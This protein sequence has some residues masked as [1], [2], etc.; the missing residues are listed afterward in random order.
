M[1]TRAGFA[2]MV[3][4]ACAGSVYATPGDTLVISLGPGGVLGNLPSIAPSI[5]GDA[6][7]V[8]FQSSA[9]NL[10]AGDTNAKDDVLVRDLT[11]GANA[12]ASL[13]SGGAFGNDN[14]GPCAISADGRYVAFSSLATNLTP[15]DTNALADVFVR[16]LLTGI[17]TMVSLDAAG[18][19]S[20]GASGTPAI[21]EDGRYVAFES[22]AS[23]LVAGDT[24]GVTDIFVRDMSTG[25]T[26]RASVAT[27]GVQGFN[28]SSLRPQISA[29]GRFVSFDSAATTLVAGDTNGVRDVFVRDLVNLTTTRESVSVAGAQLTDQS[30]G[31][32][33][34]TSSGSGIT[35]QSFAN[36][37][38]PGD[39]NFSA[40]IFR[41][42]VGNPGSLER[43]TVNPVTGTQANFGSSR[44]AM[45][46]DGRFIAF[47][48]SATNLVAGDTNNKDDIFRYDALVGVIKRVNVNSGGN[49]ANNSSANP[50]ISSDGRIIAF[51]SNATNLDPVD[52]T[53]FSD[54][55]VHET[56]CPSDVNSD[57]V[58][59][60]A[61][62]FQFFNDF[63]QSLPGADITGDANVDLADFFAFLNAFDA[64]C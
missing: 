12:A 34:M 56:A 61:D 40:D 16:D 44:P 7:R 39:T 4:A 24:N 58:V 32:A 54:V 48:S 52:T 35:F 46:P 8:A 59:D 9:S 31:P 63:D 5:S 15:G 10:V 62:F 49:E 41:K 18:G 25:V 6:T 17:T 14:S 43:I 57:G 50:A 45:T 3:L 22:A 1:N 37:A 13:N 20:N 36:N 2:A 53:V 26:V 55:Y 27:G 33:P 60:L 47:V 64:N 29:D 51:A 42:L 28:G 21:S 30:L 23:D 19:P 38:V 11:A